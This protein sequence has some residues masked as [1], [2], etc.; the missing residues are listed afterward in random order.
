MR[1]LRSLIE[2]NGYETDCKEVFGTM[3]KADRALLGITWALARAIDLSEYP[4]VRETSAGTLRA[5]KTLPLVAIPAVVVYFTVS[6]DDQT[7][8]LHGA[9]PAMPSDD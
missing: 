7:V 3:P 2:E 4:L 5:A 9:A 1:L 8:F 6:E